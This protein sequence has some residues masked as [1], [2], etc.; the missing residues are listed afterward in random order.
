MVR[1]KATIGRGTLISVAPA[2][3]DN[4]WPEATA[5]TITT[6]PASAA[7]AIA[8]SFDPALT[9]DIPASTTR[10]LYLNFIEVSGKSHFVEVTSPITP[11]TTSLTVKAL[12]QGITNGAIA[13][14]PLLLANAENANL[15][16]DK[17]EAD[18]NV[19]SG[20]GYK[21]SMTTQL[22]KGFSMSTFCSQLDA[23][24]NTCLDASNSLEY[25][26]VYIKLELPKPKGYTNNGLTFEFFSGIKAPFS[27]SATEIIK[28]DLTGMSRGE[29]KIT[30]AA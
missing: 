19:F 5:I 30:K 1:S 2:E 7:V 10:P 24:W 8:V 29:F 23:A 14:F 11:A 3:G 15:S 28:T 27:I 26:E 13:V 21:D 4:V 9:R 17:T 18:I 22:A 12:K 6:A 20:D 25:D 16:D